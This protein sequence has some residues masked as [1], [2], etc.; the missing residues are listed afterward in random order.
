[1]SCRIY[2][3][4][5]LEECILLRRSQHAEESL[6]LPLTVRD[7]VHFFELFFLLMQIYDCKRIMAASLLLCVG[8]HLSLSS[9]IWE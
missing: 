6:T 3:E 7:M 4:L 5:T 2:E 8:V 9:S 1:M